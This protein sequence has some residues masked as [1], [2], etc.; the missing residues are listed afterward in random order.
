M[1]LK[2][3]EYSHRAC[4]RLLI[5]FS[6]ISCNSLVVQFGNKNL[7]LCYYSWMD[8]K[9]ILGFIPL[10]LAVPSYGYYIHRVYR[11]GVKPHM[12]SWLIWSILA[13][14]G[15]VGQLSDNAGPGAWNTGIT[16]VGCFSIFIVSIKHGQRKLTQLDKLLLTIAVFAVLVLLVSENYVI[17]TL[18]AVV[19]ALIGFALTFIKAFKKP[20]EETPVTFF[21]N[22]LRNFISLFALN[23]ISFLTFFYPFVVMIAGL[24]IVLVVLI[25]RRI[26]PR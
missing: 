2:R 17:S 20:N 26:S 21:V 16:V 9:T 15:F 5:P 25:R 8:T 7:F 13:G 18:M 24:S 10:L 12:Y 14:V 6:K 23:S 4:K 11:H 19:A 22:S 3:N 1:Q